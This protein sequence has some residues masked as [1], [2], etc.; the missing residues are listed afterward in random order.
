MRILKNHF[1]SQEDLREKL[2]L[3]YTDGD[4]DHRLTYGSLQAS[5]LCLFL[6]LNLGML[7]AVRTAPG[8]SW[9][10]IAER[11]MPVLNLALQNVALERSKMS[12]QMEFLIKSKSI[13]ADVHSSAQHFPQLKTE[14]KESMEE[15]VNLLNS[16][17]RRMTLKGN[18]LTTYE[19]V[20]E[21]DVHSFFQCIHTIDA[22]LE[23]DALRSQDLRKCVKFKEFV[24]TH[25]K[26]TQYTYQIRKCSGEKCTYCQNNPR[27]SHP[28]CLLTCISCRAQC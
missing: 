4:P 7:I 2:L 3:L 22:T 27:L 6:Q 15:V 28:R 18:Q 16:R 14:Y 1:Y 13:I 10:N 24:A 17:F 26:A 19:G 20:K 9:T 23:Q 25:C 21:N 12:S 11:V 8:N 5:L